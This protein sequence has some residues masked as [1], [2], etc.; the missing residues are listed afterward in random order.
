MTAAVNLLHRLR[1]ADIDATADADGLRLRA[2][3]P[4]PHAKVHLPL[5]PEPARYSA[6]GKH[7]RH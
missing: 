3:T 2:R 7:A 4:M 1:A 5:G 6:Y